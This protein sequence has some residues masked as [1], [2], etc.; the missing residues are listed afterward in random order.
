MP[1]YLHIPHTPDTARTTTTRSAP[2]R[3]T[4]MRAPFTTITQVLQVMETRRYK[5]LKG[6]QEDDG[7]HQ[8]SRQGCKPLQRM[9]ATLAPKGRQSVLPPLLW[10]TIPPLAG[11]FAPFHYASVSCRRRASLRFTTC[12]DD[13]YAPSD[14]W[15]APSDDWYAPSSSF[16]AFGLICGTRIKHF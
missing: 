12:L 13:W 7:E 16:Q 9:A 10:D 6:R 2:S 4:S 3:S 11:V 5:A 8:S 14:D 15:Y 1:R